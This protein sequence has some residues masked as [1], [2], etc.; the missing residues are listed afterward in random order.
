MLLTQAE[1]IPKGNDWIYE[2]KYDGFRCLLA[3]VDEPALISRDGKNLNQQ[4]P[5][6]ID[7]L[8]G[9]K[10]K[11]RAYLPLQLDGELVFLTNNFKSEFSVIQ[12]RGRM[13]SQSSI[14]KHAVEFPCHFAAFDVLQLKGENLANLELIKRKELLQKFGKGAELPTSIHYENQVR[15]QIIDVFLNAGELWEK[16]KIHNGE[17]LISKKK[18]SN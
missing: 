13:R 18:K 12:L 2:I 10:D 15:L 8:Q 4:F 11:I 9:I 5:E 7:F 1:E 14:K 3:W 6:I 17:G 16:I